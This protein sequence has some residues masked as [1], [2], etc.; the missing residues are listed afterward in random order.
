MLVTG[1]ASGDAHGAALA[2]ELKSLMPQAHLF[3]MG[4]PAMAKAG[5]EIIFDAAKIAVMGGVE[6][7][8]RL[9]VIFKAFR[10]L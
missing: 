6:V 7:I 1:E 2:R 4:G 5:V 10:I 3:G 9:P 8:A